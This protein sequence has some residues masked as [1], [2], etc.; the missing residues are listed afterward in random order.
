MKIIIDG[1][2]CIAENGEYILQIAKRNGI[3][4]PTLCYS[5]SLKG[6]SACRICIVEIEERGKRKVVTSCNYPV[7][8]EIKVF[9][10]SDKI[11]SIRKTLLMLILSRLKNASSLKELLNEYEVEKNDRFKNMEEDNCIMCGLCVKACEALGSNAIGTAFRGIN[12]KISTPFEE[13]PE[14]CIGCTSCASVCPVGVIKYRDE[15]GIRHIW[16]GEFKLVKCEQC[17]SYYATEKQIKYIEEK[18]GEKEDI[19]LCDICKKKLNAKN[20]KEVFKNLKK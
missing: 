10:H 18:T 16:N 6:L 3:N 8:S 15:D 17:G 5:E 12:K 13:P 4:I 2:E 19:H 7:K 1:K 9:T 14:N 11:I 20:F